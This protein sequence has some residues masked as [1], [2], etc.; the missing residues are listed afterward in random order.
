[1]S[2]LSSRPTFCDILLNQPTH[3]S[4]CQLQTPIPPPIAK[5][6]K[7]RYDNVKELFISVAPDLQGINAWR[8]RGQISGG[9]QEFVEAISFQHYLET[10]KLITLSET[11]SHIPGG[12]ELTANDYLLGIYDLTGE[13]MRFGI[14]SMATTGVMPRGMGSESED[15]LAD[16]RLLRA[17]LESLDISSS[18]KQKVEVMRQSVDKVENAACSMIIRGRERPKGW[19][20]ELSE[21]RR[22]RVE[23]Y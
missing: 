8:Y 4:V 2:P 7:P 20:P 18:T 17:S 6:I 22:E 12:I 9:C 14:T 3:H 11:Q 15:L 5:E 13:L 23:S 1:M 21:G 16:L 10:Q 19:V